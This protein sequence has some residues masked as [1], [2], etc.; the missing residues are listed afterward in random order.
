MRT[1]ARAVRRA[2]LAA[3]SAGGAEPLSAWRAIGARRDRRPARLRVATEMLRGMDFTLLYRS[4]A[5]LGSV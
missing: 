5:R 3:F 1:S 4:P 2:L